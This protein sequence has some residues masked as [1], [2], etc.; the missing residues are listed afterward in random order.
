MGTIVVSIILI[1]IVSAKVI[2][3]IKNKK[4]GVSIFSCGCGCSKCPSTSTCHNKQK[5]K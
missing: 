2:N 4:K 1:A 3:M 5:T